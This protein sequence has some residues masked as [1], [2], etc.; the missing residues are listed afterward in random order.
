MAKTAFTE[1]Y[2]T[3]VEK[4]G[5]SPHAAKW[6]R[7]VEHVS[8]QGGAN[9]YAVCTAALGQS[10][11]KSMDAGDP[12]FLKEVDMF[13]GKLGI[14]GAGPVPNSL[15]ARQDLDGTRKSRFEK[16]VETVEKAS[17]KCWVV[18]CD[19]MEQGRFDNK[20]DAEKCL[21]MYR[22]SGTY[23][24]LVE[25]SVVSETSKGAV[26]TTGKQLT[27]VTEAAKKADTDAE[28]E[29]LVG[30]IKNIQLKRQKATI[31]EREKEETTKTF[32][33]VWKGISLK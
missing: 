29:T 31:F 27:R 23:A 13:L 24:V 8:Q 17:S 33:E 5:E 20:T 30:R 12:N 9:A 3:L 2:K 25:E 15:L 16:S 1:F 26:E 18:R 14:S 28:S 32:K 11:F 7:C 19:G 22:S 6:D 10:A 4:P 21:D